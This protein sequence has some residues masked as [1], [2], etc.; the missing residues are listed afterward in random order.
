MNSNPPNTSWPDAGTQR[1]EYGLFALDGD[2]GLPLPLKVIDVR[3]EVAGDCAQVSIEQIFEF[4]GP[5]PVD[6][7]Y[8]F[9]LPE[10]AS[11][12]QC[13]MSV[14]DRKVVAVVKAL[15]VARKAYKKA[16]AARRR[17]ALVETVR[18]NLFELQLGNVQP[19]D[20]I[21]IALSFASPLPAEGRRRRLRVP[22]CPGVR[23]IPGKPVGVDGGTDL[24][25]DA[26][27]LLPLRIGKNHPD[28]ATF[29]CAGTILNA[30]GVESPSHE[31]EI[32]Q[33][34]Q[35]GTLAVMLSEDSEVPDRD[36]VL[37]WDCPIEPL[38]LIAKDDPEYLLCSIQ[39]P[40]SFGME[41][42]PRDIFFLL[43]AS[44]SMCG[45]NWAALCEA[46][47]LAL[48]KLDSK[49]RLSVALF[50]DCMLSVTD[51]LVAA[52]ESQ[53]QAVLEYLRR[54]R[55]NGGTEFTNAFAETIKDAGHARRPVIVVVTDGQF[56][57]ESRACAVARD[58]GIEVHTIGIDA[59]VNEA[60]L[61]KIARR[62]CGTCS[63]AVPGE[64]LD[65]TIHQLVANLLSPMIDR[66]S[67]GP[68]WTVVGS[69]PPLR[70]GQTALIPFHRIAK[71]S[72][73]SGPRE[74]EI[75]MTFTDGSHR[76]ETLEVRSATGLA[77]AILA[78]K[79]RIT[80]HLDEGE[81]K[82]AV[83]LAC[84]FNV[85]CEGAA[86]LAVDESEHVAVAKV[87]LEQPSQDID[88][89]LLAIDRDRRMIQYAECKMCIPPERMNRYKVC[90][91][92]APRRSVISAL[93]RGAES[94]KI[95]WIE[96]LGDAK[97][98]ALAYAKRI[99]RSDKLVWMNSLAQAK[100]VTCID[101]H[102][103]MEL[104]ENHLVPWAMK[105]PANRRILDRCIRDLVILSENLTTTTEI[106]KCL[107][108]LIP[109][110]PDEARA[111]TSAL[112]Q[113]LQKSGWVSFPSS[114]S[115]PQAEARPD[116]H[117]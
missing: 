46:V 24:V 50:S 23:F 9:P 20:V 97:R 51:G 91:K 6:V 76:R 68:E 113:N 44:G 18:A 27:R 98:A 31:V 16:H 100:R 104:F 37:T 82:E 69:P 61:R 39:A 11:V 95:V 22:L 21:T 34:T 49:D 83:K 77:P 54:Y 108:K 55:P 101:K 107:S 41:R 7:L 45:A 30:A 70:P 115:H 88:D 40:D 66:I 1:P 73:A 2:S 86:F 117:V 26:S 109:F 52:E 94:Y 29:F 102:V 17:A 92:R 112:I 13:T 96:F 111:H 19:G 56:G 33:A 62:T 59:N 103:W 116:L 72:D 87:V 12:Y 42:G 38:A 85:V 74:V 80:A 14:G 8:T 65:Q 114:Y 15:E 90:N 71:S 67:A 81:V 32:L 43:D 48:T 93:L 84:R 4:D 63:L 89:M 60:A 106:V 79:A 28:A 75:D 5:N 57:D 3:F 58:C 64:D 110:L 53:E 36:F 105:R 78:A 25:P 99:T 47:E 10:E 35:D